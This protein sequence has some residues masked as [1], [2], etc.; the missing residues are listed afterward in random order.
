MS[1]DKD[2]D[3]LSSPSI[4]LAGL[5][6]WVHGRQYPESSDYWDGNCLLVTAE[7]AS[8]GAVVRVRG[9]IIHL[10]ELARWADLAETVYS[11]LIG[12]ANLECME[13]ELSVKLAVDKL[14]HVLMTV[15]I[16]P[17][18]LAQNHSFSFELDQSYIPILIRECRT[19]LDCYPIKAQSGKA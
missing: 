18:H 5:K 17:D 9:P 11:S 15:N 3:N 10:S 19:V 6:I 13:P 14:G 16:T 2:C 12:E 8:L 7:C 1:T 4:H